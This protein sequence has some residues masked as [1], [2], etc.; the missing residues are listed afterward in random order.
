MCSIQTLVTICTVSEILTQIDRK[1]QNRTFRL[2]KMTFRAIPQPPYL[3]QHCYYP[4]EPSLC[5]MPK[6]WAA[7]RYYW[8]LYDNMAENAA[9]MAKSDLSHL[10]KWPLE[11]FNEDQNFTGRQHN[12][13]KV[14]YQNRRKFILPFWR[15]SS[16]KF[17]HKN[18]Y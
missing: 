15:I 13:R 17:R 14:P 12:H 6:E 16:L 18:Q 1:D 9:N 5:K 7:L 4:N 10:V 8:S 2:W 11:R 3:A